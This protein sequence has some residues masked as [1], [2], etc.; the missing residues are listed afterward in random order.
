MKSSA[1]LGQARA[2]DIITAVSE[3]APTADP[4]RSAAHWIVLAV[5]L[6]SPL[7]LVAARALL[8]PEPQG[9]GTHEQL[10]LP[11]CQSMDWFGV[12]CPGC[13]VTTSVAWFAHA[14]AM[15]SLQTQPL[16]FLIGAVAL[17]AAPLALFG[18]VRGVDLGEQARSFNRPRTWFALGAFACASWLYKGLAMYVS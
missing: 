9:F 1:A 5:C 16:G 2:R 7:G 10:G 17:F 6:A 4:A 18:V 15:R 12:P 3:L 13:G 8:Q 14:D 11:P